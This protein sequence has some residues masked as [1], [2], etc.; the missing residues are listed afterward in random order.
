MSSSAV[1]QPALPSGLLLRTISAEE[2][3]HLASETFIRITS[4]IDHSTFH[5][6]SGE[7]GPLVAGLPCD[8]PLWLALQLR[9]TGK[10]TIETPELMT[11]PRLELVVKDERESELFSAIPF[12]YIEVSQLIMTHAREDIKSPD[13]VQVLLQDIENIRMSRITNGLLALAETFRDRSVKSLTL[14]NISSMEI[15]A[16]KRFLGDSL[17]MFERLIDNDSVTRGF[18]VNDAYGGQGGGPAPGNQRNARPL[19]R[20]PRGGGNA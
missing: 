7:V 14:R 12:H 1:T 2:S 11:V 13:Q 3:E 4:N 20:L 18:V 8:V 17:D 19:R 9:K 5:F 16:I 10:C 15:L 6:I